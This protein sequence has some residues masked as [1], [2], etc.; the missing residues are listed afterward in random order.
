M[1][2]RRRSPHKPVRP[3]G[4]PHRATTLLMPEAPRWRYIAAIFGLALTIRFMHLWQFQGSPFALFLMGDAQSYDSW[5]QRIASG[6]WLGSQVFYQAPLYPYFL[7]VLYAIAGRDLVLVRIVQVIVGASCCSLIALVTTRL[8]GRRAGLAAGLLLVLYGPALF[9]DLLIQK[10]VLDLLFVCLLLLTLVVADRKPTLLR[11]FAVGICFGGLTLTRE[12]SLVLLP[13]LIVW[14]VSR[15]GRTPAPVLAF[16]VGLGL[17]VGPV[18]GRNIAMGSDSVLTTSQLGPNL[19]IGNSERATGTYV[20]LRSGRG[21]PEFEQQDATALAEAAVGRTLSAGEVSRYWRQ[22]ALL[23]IRQNPGAWL[24]LLGRKYLLVWNAR[25]AVDTEDI[26]SHADWSVTLRLTAAVLNFG[27][28]APLGLLGM[29]LTRS[30]WRRLWVFYAICL[31]YSISVALFYVVARY[32][33]P[34]VPMLLPFAGAAVVGLPAWWRRTK[35]RER[36][37]TLVLVS[38]LA[39]AVNWPLI[40]DN[41]MRAA[42]RYN[43][44]YEFQKAGRSD[45]AIREYSGA[46]TLWPGHAAAHANLAALLT[47]KG[48]HEDAVSHLREAIRSDPSLVEAHVNLGIELANLH[49]Y[50]DALSSLREA[51][52]LDPTNSDVHYNLA[53]CLAAMGQPAAAITHYAEVIRLKPGHARAYNNMGVLFASQGQLDEAIRSFRAAVAAQP[54]FQEAE[55]NLRRAQALKR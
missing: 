47:Q 44:G 7:G 35:P 22:R 4:D 43:L 29:W 55:A 27:V 14:L 30:Q 10:A 52:T 16:A 6:D 12:N 21:T 11:F 46:V 45:D 32:R 34:L 48:M 24:E 38:A 1:A 18:A 20:A 41:A 42:T 3:V 36:L 49:L 2:K 5:A 19:Y 13:V 39:A 17:I 37:V 8:F 33:Y 54:G 28:L 9:F 23:W 50:E 40:P 51:L 31:T 26:S 15:G 53:T 25:E